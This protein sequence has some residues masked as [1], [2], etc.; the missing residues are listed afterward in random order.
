[1]HQ[2]ETQ[3]LTYLLVCCSADKGRRP[4]L[5]TGTPPT[6]TGLMTGA[7]PHYLSDFLTGPEFITSSSDLKCGNPIAALLREAGIA[8]DSGCHCVLI[9]TLLFPG[10][11]VWW[12]VI[13][14][15]SIVW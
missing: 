6:H 12:L 10:W 5:S 3:E 14:F 4:L 8:R 13:W 1:M 15:L 2:F 9:H 7:A 11:S